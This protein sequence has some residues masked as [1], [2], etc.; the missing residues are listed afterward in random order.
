MA[1]CPKCKSNT[2]VITNNKVYR[3]QKCNHK[4]TK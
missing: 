3:C 2:A 4:F 1:M